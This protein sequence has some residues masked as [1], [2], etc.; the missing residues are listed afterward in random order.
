MIGPRGANS[1]D[2]FHPYVLAN[3]PTEAYNKA[4]KV[5]D[6]KDYGFA[7]DRELKSIE[8]IADDDNYNQCKTL[9]IL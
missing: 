2:Y 7:S 5:V 6:E 4:K 1:V 8:L 3:D 9:I